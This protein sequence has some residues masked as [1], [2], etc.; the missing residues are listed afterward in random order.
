M[1]GGARGSVRGGMTEAPRRSRGGGNLAALP[2][3]RP[4]RGSPT[5]LQGGTGNPPDHWIR[6]S[7][8]RGNDDAAYTGERGTLKHLDARFPP[9][10][11]PS[12][13]PA[14]AGTSQPCS[15][16]WGLRA[17]QGNREP[18]NIGCE[19]PAYAGTTMPLRPM[20][21]LAQPHTRER[22]GFARGISR[23]RRRGLARSDCAPRSGAPSKPDSTS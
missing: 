17:T 9:T 11:R 10:R 22:R 23:C 2:P 21:P 19:V 20:P 12:V 5:R 1:G 4:A 18:S 14:K 16:A 15:P 3:C 13:V 8:L 7:R 6:G